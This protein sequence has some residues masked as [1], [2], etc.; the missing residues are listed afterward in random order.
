MGKFNFKDENDFIETKEKADIFYKNIGQIYC[1]YLKEKITFNA[2]GLRHL[3]FKS[4]QQA[5]TR[6]DQYSRLKLL[7]LAPKVL[8]L[9]R[10][11]QGIWETKI[12]ENQ[13]TNSKWKHV[14]KPVLFFEFIAVLDNVRIKVIVKEVFGGE[15][16]FWSIV[17]FWR[18]NKNTNKRILHGGNPEND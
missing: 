4:D 11:V 17:P 18:I 3:K 12:F 13:K 8:E 14:L 10:T 16:H 5:R 2:K 15:K 7:P 6:T 1:P 9:S